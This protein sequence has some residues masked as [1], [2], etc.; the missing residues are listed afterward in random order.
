MSNI[1]PPGPPMPPGIAAKVR[2]LSH[3][4][5]R[6]AGAN[7]REWAGRKGLHGRKLVRALNASPLPYFS[8]RE[9]D[10]PD[11]NA[12]GT[13]ISEAVERKEVME[14][15]EG[16]GNGNGGTPKIQGIGNGGRAPLDW[17]QI[18]LVETSEAVTGAE[19]VPGTLEW[20]LTKVSLESGVRLFLGDIED[21]AGITKVKS[22]RVNDTN[23]QVPA[24]G[25]S[26]KPALIDEVYKT[27]A[28][29]EL[30]PGIEVTSMLGRQITRLDIE[31]VMADK[32]K[33][34]SLYAVYPLGF[35]RR[36][37]AG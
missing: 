1:I 21:G 11:E 22:V 26:P 10:E 27:G 15:L 28:V 2:R 36:H 34:V 23:N 29:V 6:E 33:T 18:E 37:A 24:K 32:R 19:A 17:A 8:R 7:F 31:L 20:S 5:R 13:M 4:P 25:I 3:L 16:I 35:K 9:D 14:A 12:L 30:F